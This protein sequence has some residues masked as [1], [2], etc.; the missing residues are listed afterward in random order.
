M[1]SSL[2]AASLIVPCVLSGARAASAFEPEVYPLLV[3][4][5]DAKLHSASRVEGEDGFSV[6]RLRLGARAQ[7]APWFVAVGQAEWALEKPVLLDA[8][9][10]LR[11][12]DSW[13]ISMGARKTPLFASAR[14]DVVW[15]LPVPE[16]PMVTRAFWPSRDVGLEV[17]HLPSPRL[18]IEVWVRGGNGSGNI[19]GNDNSDF[20]I[21]AR[22]DAV[23]GRALP[24]ADPTQL[25]GLRV[26]GGVHAESA[27]DRPGVRATTADGFIFYRPQTVYGPRRI[28]EAHVVGMVGPVKATAEITFARESRA[29]DTDGNP[30]TPRV[31][32]DPVF[33]S[34]AMLEVAW[35]AVGAWR[36]LGTWPTASG[37]GILPGALEV[38]GRLERIDLAYGARDVTPG[39]ATAA[40][41]AVRWWATPFAALSA[42]LY[43]TGY[44]V[45]P[46]ESPDATDSW[47][48]LV[49]ATFHM[50]VPRPQ[51][52]GARG[53]RK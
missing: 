43:W 22:L 32:Q 40:S 15:M 9:A 39:G 34:G 20:A 17:H 28:M 12:S 3:G 48:G 19:L 10:S 6:T 33:S 50:P 52:P 49:R 11:P 37:T 42:A 38:A 46:I 36:T 47:L 26:G 30:E 5:V 45:P 35:M 44:D 7:L 2:L 25:L 14:D 18:P 27:E 31:D 24:D 8:Y 21:D 29:R 41:A 23:F 53:S 13:E 4:E 51:P 16:R 1:R